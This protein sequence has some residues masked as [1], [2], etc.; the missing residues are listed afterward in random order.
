MWFV[1]AARAAF[2][3]TAGAARARCI[4]ARLLELPPI[5]ALNQPK[6]ARQMRFLGV[7]RSAAVEDALIYV[8]P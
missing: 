5:R 6:R 8:W 7:A 2:L 3:V 4:I 1:L